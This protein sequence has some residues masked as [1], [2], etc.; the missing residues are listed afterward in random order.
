[1]TCLVLALIM[2]NMGKT[3]VLKI[4]NTKVTVNEVP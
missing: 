4:V 1:M 3:I 2:V